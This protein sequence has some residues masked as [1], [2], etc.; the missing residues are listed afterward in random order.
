MLVGGSIT[1][2]L[3]ILHQSHAVGSLV[4]GTDGTLIASMGDS[5]SY[6]GVDTGGQ[7]DGGDLGLLLAAWGT[8]DPSAD[9]NGDGTVNGA[10][11]GLLLAAWGPCP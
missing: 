5:A 3:P 4:F 11:L 9:L 8:S 7:V 2:G 6:G 10:D 1:D